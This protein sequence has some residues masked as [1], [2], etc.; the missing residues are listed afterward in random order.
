MFDI[1][2]LGTIT[3]DV[4]I[5]SPLFGAAKEKS[6]VE[7][8]TFASGEAQCFA[9]G[10]KIKVEKPV[11]AGGGGAHNA[12]ITFA[13]QG[14]RTAVIGAIG[15]DLAGKEIVKSLKSEGIRPFVGTREKLGT[16]YAVILMAPGGE[17][18]ILVYRGAT[19][20]IRNEDI[21]HAKT[22][23]R[24]AYVVPGEI[25]LSVIGSFVSS[26]K[27]NG[28]KIAMN[29][30]R[31]YLSM[32]KSEIEK[33]F[34]RLDAIIMNREEA[35]LFT[36]VPYREERKI[37]KELDRIVPGIAVMTDGARG[38]SASDGSYVYRAGI[39]RDRGVLDRTGA[40]DAFGSGFVAGLLQG[41]GD[42]GHALRLGAANATSVVE[43]V[44]ATAGVLRARDFS[45][46]RW[47]NVELDIE[48]L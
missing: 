4:F 18:T 22:K 42:V 44:G 32:K 20:A 30:S 9:L 14:F 7:R 16:G 21:S 12:A 19:D 39:F 38:A 13:R 25:P 37:F 36:N 47:K 24:W 35:S 23:A 34:G 3:R 27:K 40:G 28:T 17:R 26:M 15:D 48:R 1:V 41:G 46:P 6:R 45:R 29:P 31:Q 11:F 2:T 8:I 5:R 43:C 33:L 10:S